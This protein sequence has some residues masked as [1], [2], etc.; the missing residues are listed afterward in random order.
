MTTSAVTNQSMTDKVKNVGL[1]FFGAVI[2]LVCLALFGS[3]I[4]IFTI[5]LCLYIGIYAIVVI[6]Y[7]YKK[8]NVNNP[9]FNLIINV[10]M[11]TICLI[12]AIA[13]YAVYLMN[14]SYNYRI[15]SKY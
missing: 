10:S 14:A 8:A 3:N 7:L 12:F 15:P 2:I 1:M 4:Y 5:F 9:E 6:I 13:L 11:Y